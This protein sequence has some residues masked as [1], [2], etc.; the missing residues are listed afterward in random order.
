DPVDVAVRR[1]RLRVGDAERR[2]I[3][4]VADRAAG[5]RDDVGRVGRD[6]LDVAV[7]IDAGG[8]RV[9]A[10]EALERV[11]ELGERSDDRRT[12]AERDR[13]DRKVADGD[14]QLLCG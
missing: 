3:G 6:D 7:R 1:E 12:V 4:R 2:D 5:D 9:D 14:E 13:L 10:G 11:V 8:G